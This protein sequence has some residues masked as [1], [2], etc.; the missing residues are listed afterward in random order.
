MNIQSVKLVYF[1]P[2]HTSK[3]VIL[4]I[5]QGMDKPPVELIDVTLPEA[6]QKILQVSGDELLMVA[7]PV[8]AGRVPA[9]LPEWLATIKA[10]NTPTGLHCG[11]RK[12]RV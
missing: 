11:L 1:S 3:K 9:F 2:T 6:R 4:S 10:H 7:V 12:P 8:Y 5:V